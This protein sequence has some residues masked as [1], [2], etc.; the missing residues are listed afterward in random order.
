[1]GCRAEEVSQ[2]RL[3]VVV[4]VCH[5]AAGIKGLAASWLWS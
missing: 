5:T 2:Q 4:T 1:V 3:L